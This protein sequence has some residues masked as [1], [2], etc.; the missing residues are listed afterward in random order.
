MLGYVSMGY[1]ACRPIVIFGKLPEPGRNVIGKPY[2]KLLVKPCPFE[3]K[4]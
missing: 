1:L 4:Q 2:K 3:G